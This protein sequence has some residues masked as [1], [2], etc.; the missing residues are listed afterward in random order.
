MFL[1]QL[2]NSVRLNMILISIF[3][4]KKIHRATEKEAHNEKIL[5]LADC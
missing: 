3:N 2:K 4:P 1:F 5:M